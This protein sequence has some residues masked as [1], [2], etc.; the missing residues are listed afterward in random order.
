RAK[1]RGGKGAPS[2]ATK[3]EGEV[4]G[5]RGN[6]MGIVPGMVVA[7]FV[8]P[9]LLEATRRFVDAAGG[10][11][12]VQLA[13]IT[14]EPEDRLPG[15]LRRGLAGHWRIDDPLDAGQIA[16]AVQ[17]LGGNLGAVER[18]LAVL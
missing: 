15:E 4:G 9:Y 17:G 2:S 6:K 5:E 18:L 1:E 13:L 7:A 12:D 3:G 10:L 11:P 8:A 16:A 14:C